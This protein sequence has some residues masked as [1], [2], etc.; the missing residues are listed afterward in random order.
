MKKV[1]GLFLAL[2]LALGLAACGGDGSAPTIEGTED[3]TIYLDEEF[4][5]ME[6]VTATDN[7]GRDITEDI[8][9][10]GTV[11]TGTVGDYY[12]RYS[13]EDRNGN[14]TEEARYVT[15]AVDPDSI[16]DEMVPNGDFSMGMA[17]WSTTTGLEGGTGNFSV[18]DDELKIEILSVGGGMWEPRLENIGITFE[19][20]ES[21]KVSFEA[22][23][24]E[25]R[26]VHVQ[27]GELLP[28]APWFTDFKP[29]Q[30]VIFDLT[31]EMQTFEF[32]FTM[33][34]P[35]ND[36]GAMIF[37]FGTVPGAADNYLT[38]VY[39]DNVVIET[40]EPEYS[41]PVF[42]GVE[43]I[44]VETGTVFDP[45]E[46]VIALDAVDGELELTL[47]NVTGEVD[48][49]TPGDYT[50]TYTVT[51]SGDMTTT[52]ERVVS[53]VDL[54]FNETDII[55]NGDFDEDLDADDPEW[56]LWQADWDPNDSP[57]T[58]GSL[59]LS[60]G[61]MVL[62]VNDIGS[63][64]H[65]GWLLQATQ[66]IELQVG[67]TY[68]VIFEAKAAAERDID[69]V[70]G[71]TDSA[72][73]W[74]QHG[75]GTFALTTELQTFEYMFTVTKDS[76]DYQDVFKVEFGHADDTVYVESVEIQVYAEG[77][78][79]SNGSF[80]DTGWFMWHQDWDTTP[81]VDYGI[82]D[83]QMVVTISENLGD[84]NWSIQLIQTDIAMTPGTTYR[85]T[86]DAKSEHARDINFKFIEGAAGGTE[87]WEA[88]TI[89]E[90]MDTYTFDFEFDSEL[91]FGRI[92]IELGQIG[93]AQP[94]ELIFDNISIVELDDSDDV[95][96]GTERVTNGTFDQVVDWYMWHQDW[97]TAPVVDMAV[98]DGEL[99]V[100]I[101]E[102][103]G[104][105]NWAI[106]VFQHGIE[107]T[108]GATYRISF[109]MR[110]DHERDINFKFIEGAE[111]GAE[112]FETFTIDET[113]T[114]YS[115]TFTFD[116]LLDF[117][118]LNIELG[119]IGDAQPGVV[120]I[121]NVMIY[122]TFND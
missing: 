61:Q 91:D 45:L 31:T 102:T 55:K 79:Q 83:E 52:V 18:V 37:E 11:D 77:P 99:V 85:V 81:V 96:E 103:L 105:A 54:I 95:V 50:L 63:W 101:T 75:G 35:T 34:L 48:T 44:S 32:V 64:G 36:N 29:T 15:V 90:T 9:I 4:D 110:S 58:D 13:V 30:Q 24:E 119:Q 25:P 53:V 42:Q 116:S 106:Q 17:F 84:H 97:D 68:K 107:M 117:G 62:E 121:D 22:R 87:F 89:G 1:F 73:N 98:V 46:G 51:N 23:A 60:G 40:S 20:G 108:P 2:T 19:E 71:Y 12:L 59:S 66:D 16:G 39:L 111:G 115:F 28:S 80:D 70:V 6:G 122:R 78:L 72:H 21:Y 112:F 41:D 49:D 47:D 113:M 26:P 94:G 14:K 76:G 65:Q 88:F 43:N 27:V 118:R 104:D 109:D 56:Y 86:F 82:V 57:M 10:V 100:T 120:T 69:S 38:T 5:P 7:R 3:I 33:T 114:T 67:Y 93:D 92:S 8:T 74:N